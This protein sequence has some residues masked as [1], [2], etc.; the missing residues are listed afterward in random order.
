MPRT[1]LRDVAAA[2]TVSVATASRALRGDRR[3]SAATRAR[4]VAAAAGLGYRPDPALAS[5]A[6]YRQAQAPPSG[7]ETI[8]GLSTWPP[9][10]RMLPE[11]EEVGRRCAQLGFRLERIALD[12]DP[13]AQRACGERLRARGVRGLLLGTGQVQQDELDLPW[14]HFACISVSGAPRM[15]LHHSVTANYAHD[16]RLALEQVGRRGYRRPGLVLFPGI[17]QATRADC[18]AGWSFA[19]GLFPAPIAAPL[20]LRDRPSDRGACLDWVD[21]EGIDVVLSF[22]SAPLAWLRAAGRRQVGFASLDAATG[23]TAGVL[24]PRLACTLVAIDLLAAR[25]RNHEYGPVAQPFALQLDGAWVD[26]PT[27]RPAP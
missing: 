11:P 3:I 20:Q 1:L 2:A 12:A 13:A 15:R 6:A 17:L 7:V 8:V 16:L 19:H 24:Q 10:S 22:S 21:A 14:E 23:A 18:V 26:G 5:L 4:V 25:L 9:R 27:L